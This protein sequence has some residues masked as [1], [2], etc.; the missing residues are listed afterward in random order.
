MRIQNCGG[1]MLMLMLFNWEGHWCLSDCLLPQEHELVLC[2]GAVTMAPNVSTESMANADLSFSVILCHSLSLSVILCHSLIV[3]PCS[4]HVLPCSDQW[5]SPYLDLPWRPSLSADFTSWEQ[6]RA[7]INGWVTLSIVFT[8]AFACQ[9]T[10]MH[11][12]STRSPCATIS[13]CLEGVSKCEIRWNMWN[14]TTKRHRETTVTRKMC[15]VWVIAMYCVMS[16][17]CLHRACS[18]AVRCKSLLRSKQLKI[19]GTCFWAKREA[20][21]KKRWEKKGFQGCKKRLCTWITTWMDMKWHDVAMLWIF[22]LLSTSHDV[23]V[24]QASRPQSCRSRGEDGTW[25]NLKD[26]KSMTF[27]W[28]SNDIPMAHHD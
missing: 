6:N 14:W 5:P 10:Q 11:A 16:E 7:F 9:C 25:W 18:P 22:S 26:G 13:W 19:C 23:A 27:Q 21:A 28:H 17:S 4:S 8:C 24:E 2:T 3:L 20:K 15:D 12:I 1:E